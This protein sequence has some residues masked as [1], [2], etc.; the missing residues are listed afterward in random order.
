MNS[1]KNTGNLASDKYWDS[2]YEKLD[3]SPMPR[4]YPTVEMLYRCLDINKDGGHPKS[5]FEIGVYPGRFIYHFGKLGFVLNGIDQT[6]YIPRLA[7]W[8]QQENFTVGNIMQGDVNELHSSCQQYDVV[9][10]AGFIEH[11]PEFEK[12]ILLHAQLV[13]PGGY[14]YITAPNFGGSVQYRLHKWLDKENLK[15]HFVPS[16][17][18]AKWEKVL[19]QNGFEIISSGYI[20]GI[21]FWVDIQERNIAQKILL[22]LVKWLLPLA[23][24][25]NLQNR[26]AYS[27]ECALIAQ[28]KK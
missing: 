3:F 5:V 13:K 8:L 27:P 21:D 16:M 7:Q 9:F 28:R 2:S 6:Q 15:R 1:E 22:K 25:M 4:K 12:M 24:K 26:R 19:M 18:V 20:G 10:S 17:D 23:K 11:F 14:V